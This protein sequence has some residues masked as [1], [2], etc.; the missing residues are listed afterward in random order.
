MHIF[1]KHLIITSYISTS[2]LIAVIEVKNKK[3]KWLRTVTCL[4]FI[5]CFP[6]NPIVESYCGCSVILCAGNCDMSNLCNLMKAVLQCQHLFCCRYFWYTLTVLS[7]QTIVLQ[8]HRKIFILELGAMEMV[9]KIVV[10]MIYHSVPVFNIIHCIGC[11]TFSI[12]YKRQ[13]ASQ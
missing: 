9:R 10:S 3:N 11:N 5:K 12:L 4:C 8:L 1:C 13:N 6:D 7:F 2:C